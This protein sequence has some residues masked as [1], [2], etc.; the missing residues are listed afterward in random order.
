MRSVTLAHAKRAGEML[1]GDNA[2]SFRILP[3][4]GAAFVVAEADGT[5]I[6]T[7]EGGRAR[8]ERR[9]RQWKEMRLVAARAQG[10]VEATYG[11]TFGSVEE[12]GRRWG[13]CTRDAGWALESCIHVV[14]DGAEWIRLQSQETFGNQAQLL[15]DFYH[16][17]EYLAAAAPRC[18]PKNPRAWCRTQHRRLKRGEGKKV[19]K[20]METHIEARTVSD[21]EAFVRNAY[22]Y[23]ANRLDCI[24]YPRA[25]A[26]ELPIG[27]G[28][29][30]SGHKHV[31][32]ARLK[33]SGAA[34]LA[35]NADAIAQLRVLR[36]NHRWDSFWPAS[37][38]A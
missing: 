14:A 23:L 9:P 34:W 38:A 1:E 36:A 31:L 27:S 6:C 3:K 4:R 37:Q 5:M 32:Q 28:L 29:I 13:H 24:D 17:S 35:P 26:H 30:E 16:V 19:L 21:E 12:V 2:E 11:A 10:E 8:N 20:A 25:I 7:V 33:R 18:H 22:R 15:V